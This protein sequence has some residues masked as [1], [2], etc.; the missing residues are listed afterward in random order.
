MGCASNM[1]CA[2]P[3]GYRVPEVCPIKGV[4]VP[5][6]KPFMGSCVKIL[7]KAFHK[8]DIKRTAI[9]DR[10]RVDFKLTKN[11]D[12][13]VPTQTDVVSPNRKPKKITRQI[14]VGDA[15]PGV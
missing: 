14:F 9:E 6:H 10:N 13:F 7:S 12:C 1:F 15:M 8:I 3:F 2:D 11:I 5:D 4:F